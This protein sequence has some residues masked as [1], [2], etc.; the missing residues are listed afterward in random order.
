MKI[1]YPILLL[2]ILLSACNHQSNEKKAKKVIGKEKIVSS[3]KWIFDSV[4]GKTLKFK[5]GKEFSTEI[6]EL[7]YIGQVENGSKAPFLIFSGRDC[8]ECDANITIYIHTPADGLLV[9]DY[10]QNRYGYPGVETD[11]EENTPL[12][13]AQAFYGEVLPGVKGVVWYQNTLTENDTWEKSTFLVTLINGKKK[14]SIIKGIEKQQ[15]TLD[16]LSKKS[17]QEIKGIDYT[18]EP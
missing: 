16:L 2:T 13:K 7:K 11:F 1:I 17:C 9:S 5:N 15:L 10:G 3:N 6:Y 4:V 12:Y 14:E 8:D 18:S